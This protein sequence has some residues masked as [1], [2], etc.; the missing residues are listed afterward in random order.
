MGMEF[1]DITKAAKAELLPLVLEQESWSNTA[2]MEYRAMFVS[3]SLE[4]TS[5]RKGCLIE[6]KCNEKHRSA[7]PSPH[8]AYV[9]FENLITVLIKH[10]QQLNDSWMRCSIY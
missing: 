7:K 6:N 2:D 4:L 9:L 8:L 10:T 3:P 1:I 5:K